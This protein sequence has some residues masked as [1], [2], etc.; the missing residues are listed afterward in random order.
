[1]RSA[2]LAFSAAILLAACRGPSADVPYPVPPL[3]DGAPPP[4]ADTEAARAAA[5]AGDADALAAL[6]SV[7]GSGSS[8]PLDGIDADLG[9]SARAGSVGSH[10]LLA[11]RVAEDVPSAQ[12]EYARLLLEGVVSLGIQ[13]ELALAVQ[14]LTRAA[15]GGSDDAR[16]ALCLGYLHGFELG[17][18]LF[19]AHVSEQQEDAFAVCSELATSGHPGA[20][21]VMGDVFRY[22]LAGREPDGAAAFRW[23]AIPAGADPPYVDGLLAMAEML[24]DPVEG[25]P[26]ENQQEAIRLLQ[27]ALLAGSTHAALRLAAFFEGGP[28]LFRDHA[29]A[30]R[31]W[32]MADDRGMVVGAWGLARS[33]RC[34]IG[35]SPSDVEHDYWLSRARAASGTSDVL[36]YT[37]GELVYRLGCSPLNPVLVAPVPGARR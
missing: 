13:P 3:P 32:S 1:M 36:G 4:P 21:V 11:R 27:R 35:T 10:N 8:H 28:E 15:A 9:I 26:A 33:F 7:P 34:G 29:T 16:Y 30:F 12:F 25:G 6:S 18:V 24:Q 17:G 31:V 5:V 22:G 2:V 19:D 20:L 14:Y 23:Y 37:S